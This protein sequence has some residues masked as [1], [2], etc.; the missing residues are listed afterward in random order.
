ML[1]LWPFTL[2]PD[3]LLGGRL[4][5]FLPPAPPHGPPVRVESI[6]GG[7]EI[8]ERC[9]MSVAAVVCASAEVP[10]RRSAVAVECEVV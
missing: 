7:I 6:T 2:I 8:G 1:N 10:Y 4:R 9:A 3:A 5:Y